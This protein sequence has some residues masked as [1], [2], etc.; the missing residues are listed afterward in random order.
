[1]CKNAVTFHVYFTF[2]IK[3]QINAKMSDYTSPA[4]KH[5]PT[6]E[7]VFHN[8]DMDYKIIVQFQPEELDTV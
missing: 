1:M 3:V 6:A 7:K 2:H 4:K 8:Q 5:N